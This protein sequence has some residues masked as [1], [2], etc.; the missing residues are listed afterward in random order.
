MTKTALKRL[1]SA[2]LRAATRVLA[3]KSCEV[4]ADLLEHLAEI[5]ERK[6]Y[7]AWAYASLF[8]YCQDELGFSE[9]AAYY[10]IT[11]AR[12]IGRFP[13]MLEFV[14]S[15][16]IHLAGLRTLVPHLTEENHQEILARAAG[17][18]RRQIEEIA[19]C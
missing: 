15:G 7:A 3:T 9:D 18:T 17:K 5:D 10:R 1:S 2:D 4:E 13:A 12:A 19:V 11:V 8:H 16:K 6:L 14:R